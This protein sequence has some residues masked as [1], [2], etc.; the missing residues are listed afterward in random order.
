MNSNITLK[1]LI[2]SLR[3]RA[4]KGTEK[5]TKITRKQSTQQQYIPINNYS[6]CK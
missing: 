3:N 5:S 2:K 4:N 1:I 6:K